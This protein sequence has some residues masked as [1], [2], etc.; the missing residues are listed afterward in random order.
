MKPELLAVRAINQYRRRD[1]LAYLGLRYYLE[2]DCA[3]NNVWA[4]DISTYLVETRESPV[5]YC[6][7]HFKEINEGQINHR[8][9]YLPGPNELIA[10]A[11]LIFDCSKENAFQSSKYVYSYLFSE[12]SS[13]EGTFKNYFPGFQER[14]QSIAKACRDSDSS[15]TIV[16]Y[17]DI[18]R[19]YPSIKS[20]LALKA[21]QSACE[22]S[23]ISSTCRELGEK[24]LAQYGE[25]SR[26]HG[27]D[28]GILTGPMFSHLIANLILSDVDQKMSKYMKGKYW[29]YVDDFVLVGS[30]NQ[31]NEGRNL[32][33]SILRDMDLLLHEEGKDFQVES[34]TWLQVSRS[35]N[36]SKSN[37]W[38]I[39]VA[40]IKRFLIANP[41]EMINLRNAFSEKGI[42]IPLLDYSNT[43]AES[44]YR[45][46]FGDWW[47]RYAWAPDSVRGLTINKLVNDALKTRSI[48]RRE[49]KILLD[50]KSDVVG[51]ER[52]QL[53]SKLRFYA[54]RLSYLATSSTLSLLSS[55]LS[56]YPELYLQSKIMDI[57]H[58]RDVSSLITLG[59]NAVQAAAQVLRIQ[60]LPVV[61]APCSFGVVEIQ[62]LAILHLNGI[63]VTFPDNVDRKVISDDPLNQFALGIEPVKLM[64]SDNLFIKEIACL[65]GIEK[66]LKHLDFLDSA[67]D[68]DEQL[69]FDI[70]DQLQVSSYF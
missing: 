21:W 53:V 57:I 68:R 15:N 8:A 50:K 25:V 51:Y 23:K 63:K 60:D 2:N 46:Q 54:V 47:N 52:K 41:Y 70:A 34:T 44:S 16:L 14:N 9:I 26:S 39:L 20:Q 10:E 4:R 19:F 49:I 58:S 64:K 59:A 37:I 55:A 45:E 1:I 30:T 5:Y 11:N 69:S 42:N 67:F 65:R 7:Y 61:C 40:N 48:Y 38:A 62:G 3:K 66:P 32:L 56:D 6:T 22:K 24:I 31:V 18:R 36:R 35:S 12:L 43:V 29:R 17:T 28:L 13:K 33:S 27:K